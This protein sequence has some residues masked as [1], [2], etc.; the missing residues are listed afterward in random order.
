MHRLLHQRLLVALSLAALAAW[1]VFVWPTPYQVRWVTIDGGT[2]P[3]AYAVRTNRVTGTTD[4][5]LIGQGWVRFPRPAVAA[6]LHEPPVV[7]T[8]EE[9][10]ARLRSQR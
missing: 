3:D 10:L 2:S 6:T 7:E 4:L 9:R 5:L 8:L 1:L